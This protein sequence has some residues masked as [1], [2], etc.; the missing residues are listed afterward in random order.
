MS[1]SEKDLSVEEKQPTEP[2]EPEEPN[3]PTRRS[4][5]QATL[6][7]GLTAAALGGSGYEL[8]QLTKRESEAERAYQRETKFSDITLAVNG[9]THQLK[10]PHQRTLLL[11]LR[12]D[13][14]LTGTK[15]GCNMGQCG[16]CTVLLDGQ[17]VYSCFL[18]AM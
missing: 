6:G 17:P 10:V 8:V 2:A 4:F 15:K 9:K 5:L 11:A 14:G 1:E 13:L 7:A 16:A 12:E 18:L 3:D